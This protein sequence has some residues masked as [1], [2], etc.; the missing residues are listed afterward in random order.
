MVGIKSVM[1]SVLLTSVFLSSVPAGASGNTISNFSFLQVG[2][3]VFTDKL[4]YAG[5]DDVLS[6]YPLQDAFLG[7][8]AQKVDC[9]L[10]HHLEISSVKS[11]RVISSLRLDTIPL[12]SQCITG[13]IKLLNDRHTQHKAQMYFK[14]YRQGN[15]NR[16]ICGVAAPSFVHPK[17]LGYRIY[18]AF[19][20]PHLKIAG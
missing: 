14:V 4:E 9:V 15:V 18:E 16:S 8:S 5:T 3:Y 19:P 17:N 10:P 7:K 20:N 1:G 11:S 13:N 6:A 2:C 12:K